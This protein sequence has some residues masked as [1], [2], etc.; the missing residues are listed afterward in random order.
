[1]A[2]Q[3]KTVHK[4]RMTEGKRAI[5]QQLFQEYNIESADDIQEALKDLLSGTIENM[6][7]AEMDEHLGYSKSERSDSDNARN[8]YKSKT[9]NSSYGRVQIDVPQDRQS[10][11]APQVVKKQELVYN[12]CYFIGGS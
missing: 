9:L 2:K 4:V 3:R 10:T 1:M 11:F 6:M 12:S 7:E 8:G 5:I